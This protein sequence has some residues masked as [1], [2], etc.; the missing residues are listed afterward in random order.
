MNILIVEDSSLEMERIRRMVQEVLPDA[1]IHAYTDSRE[2]QLEI[3]QGSFRPDV[4]FLDIE[5][6]APT[7]TELAQL[8]NDSFQKV[9]IIYAT[10]YTSYMQQALGQFVSGYLLKPFLQKDIR[11][12]LEHLRYPVSSAKQRSLYYA[13]T[14]GEFDFFYDGKP[15]SFTLTRSKE[16]LAYL[17]HINGA[18][19]TKRELFSILFEDREYTRSKQDHMKKIM[20]SLRSAL[21]QIGAGELLIHNRNA[22]AI[23]MELIATD[24]PPRANSTYM[25]QYS[26]A[27]GWRCD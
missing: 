5:M 18:S 24:K 1:Q 17:I 26:W 2:A 19:V 27:D 13:Q 15:V 25:Q 10:A 12:Q 14:L 6:P 4:A 20:Q 7:G 23:N 16:A 21:E 11:N 22:Y 3:L 8:L 9:N